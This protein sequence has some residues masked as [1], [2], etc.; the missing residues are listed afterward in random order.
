[1]NAELWEARF[2]EHLRL[3]GRTER[4]REGYGYEVRLF[5]G[6]LQDRHIGEVSGITRTELR[7]SQAVWNLAGD[8]QR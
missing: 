6:F 3:L 2:D 5:L 4:A 8:Q 7:V 1:M